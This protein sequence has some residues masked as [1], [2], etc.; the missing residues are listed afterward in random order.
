[1]K[2]G[3]YLFLTKVLQS[4]AVVFARLSADGCTA[5]FRWPQHELS[6]SKAS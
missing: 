6:F 5:T 2:I 4:E 3:V 1:M